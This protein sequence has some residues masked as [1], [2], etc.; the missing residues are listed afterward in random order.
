MK[1]ININESQFHLINE[2]Y[3]QTAFNFDKDGNAYFQKNNWQ[4]YVDFLESIGKYGM[5]PA[6]ECDDEYIS[7]AIESSEEYAIERLNNYGDYNETLEE[8]AMHKYVQD[9]LE[10]RD[11]TDFNYSFEDTEV[12]ERFN[13]FNEWY[14]QF[15]ESGKHYSSYIDDNVV[16]SFLEDVFGESVDFETFASTLNEAEQL[17]LYEYR[18]N[19]LLDERI[20]YDFPDALVMNERNLIY[21]ER[22]ISIPQFDS[23]QFATTFDDTPRDYFTYLSH[24]YGGVGECWTWQEGMGEAYDYISYKPGTTRL[25]LKGWVDPKNVNW[26]ESL[27]KNCYGLNHERELYL[28]HSTPIEIE[29]AEIHG[30]NILEKPIIVNA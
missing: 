14:Q 27:F 19:A 1:R 10:K 28:D 30:Q 9:L 4:F 21:V 25:L 15:S 3:A 7:K 5:L 18:N 8:D 2:Y 11:Y 20:T 23:P 24:H 29:R 12:A 17:E 22:E 6:S 13:N 26:D 16:S